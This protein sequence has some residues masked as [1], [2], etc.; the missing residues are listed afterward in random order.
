MVFF[1]IRK[2]PNFF[3][4]SNLNLAEGNSS[5][6]VSEE[7]SEPIRWQFLTTTLK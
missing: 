4:S 5:M 7:A 3:I 6:S 1:P 2:F